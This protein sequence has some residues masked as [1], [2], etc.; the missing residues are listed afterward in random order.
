[1]KTVIYEPATFL[2]KKY[3][4]DTTIIFFDEYGWWLYENGNRQCIPFDKFGNIYSEHPK[5]TNPDLIRMLRE[6]GPIWSRWTTKGDQYELMFREALIQIH[7]I[8][9]ALKSLKVSTFI[10]GTGVSHHI[11]DMIL[12]IAC[13][14]IEVKQ[15]FLYSIGLG[16]YRLL[17]LE[18]LDGIDS[19]RPLGVNVSEFNH[20]SD[21]SKLL[22][23]KQS[24]EKHVNPFTNK[25]SI[26]FASSVV[27]LFRRKT[28]YFLRY[29]LLNLLHRKTNSK[30]SFEK[31]PDYAL[32]THFEQMY[33]QRSALKYFSSRMKKIT[34]PDKHSFE[35]YRIV[36]A[37]H[38]QPEA[39]SFPEG[40][41]LSN[42]VD[43]VMELRRLGYKGPLLYKEHPAINMYTANIVE[44]TRVGMSRSKRYYEQLEQLGCEFV[45]SSFNLSINPIENDWYIPLTITGTIALERSLAG[46]YTIVTGHP[47]FKGLPGMLQLSEIE[48]LSEINQEWFQQ[49]PNIAKKAYNFLDKM[50]SGKTIINVIGTG[51]GI[52]LT[53]NDK[54]NSFAK[55]YDAMLT[56]IKSL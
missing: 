24:N 29:F 40:G 42:H 8:S 4:D 45:D 52:P 36:I 26:N 44:A 2:R 6:W 27:W 11:D 35:K 7:M 9:T 10:F 43:I 39:T 23:V 32:S 21:I 17:P 30:N 14:S 3:F 20:Q 13:S 12:Q 46:F 47:W 55:E 34:R 31:F 48:S 37:A 50:L 25:R 53:D 56:A 15:I 28:V 22:T 41:E 33:Q 54:M 16:E 5:T 51:T 1:M 19:R 49:D 38:Y 18:Q